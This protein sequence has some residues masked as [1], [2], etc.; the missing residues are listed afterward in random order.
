[1]T[2]QEFREKYTWTLRN[3]NGTHELFNSD[4]YGALIGKVTKSKYEKN[5]A[6]WR[7]ISEERE[8]VTP[9]YYFN[10]V[11]AVPW[12]RNAGGHERVSC[13]YCVRGYVPL[14][15]ASI[16]PDKEQKVVFKFSLF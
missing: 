11:D 4:F 3:Y 9:A 1:M 8:D 6:K 7:L 15:V 14:E 2:Y 5:G 16:S 13:G 12:F 10:T